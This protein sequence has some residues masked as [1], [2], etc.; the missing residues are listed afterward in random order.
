MRAI[1]RMTPDEF[2]H[3]MAEIDDRIRASADVLPLYAVA[4][5]SGTRMVGE[6]GFENGQLTSVGLWHGDPKSTEAFVQT[7]TTVDDVRDA[8]AALRTQT[9]A[10]AAD[11]IPE[12]IEPVDADLSVVLSVDGALHDCELWRDGSRWYAA[13]RYDGHALIVEARGIDPGDVRIVGT[14]DVEPYLDGRRSRIRSLRE[15]AGIDPPAT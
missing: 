2:W 4:D 11:D 9:R 15:Q 1:G 3:S 13:R 14:R 7:R 8:V 10:E 12:W 6:W 5:W